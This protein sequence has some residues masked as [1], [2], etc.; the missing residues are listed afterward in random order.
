MSVKIVH[1]AILGVIIFYQLPSSLA[2]E[3]PDPSDP[4]RYLNAVREFADNVLK[5]GRDT[6]GPKHTP[7]FVDGINIHT[8]EPVKWISPKAEESTPWPLLAFRANDTEEWI[9]S[10]F[11]SQQTLLR[12]LDG[13]ST[14]TGD[15]KYRDAAKEAT[16][17]ALDNL[18]APNGLFYWGYSA[19][20][21]AHADKVFI[22]KGSHTL[23]VHYPY[24]ELMWEV[25]Q[26]ATK[27]FI[28]AFWSGHILDWSNLDFC[29]NS[30]S[31]SSPLAEAWTHE[32]MGG[33]TFFQSKRSWSVGQF[34]TGTSLMHASALLYQLSD[35]VGPLVWGKR[36]MQRFVDTRHPK[37]GISAHFYNN[38]RRILPSNDMIEHFRDPYTRT[39]PF[40]PFKQQREKQLMYFGEHWQPLPW[41]SLLLMGDVL[42]E[43]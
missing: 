9:L 41:I 21:N 20:Y 23:K 13:L 3:N 1:W 6:Y 16:K 37:T 32:Y 14:V 2:T 26:K 15:P 43:N 38:K 17:Y 8:H 31:Y 7:L 34:H 4:N 33:P 35:Q 39:F 30:L 27:K 24:Y 18:I 5:Y 28:E 36:L 42:G 40:H 12:T 25:D 22:L 11:A 29:R 19:A 10:N